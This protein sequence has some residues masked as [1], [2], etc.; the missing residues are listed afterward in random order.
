MSQEIS[1]TTTAGSDL[2]T[3]V[4]LRKRDLM[5]EL[6]EHKKNSSRFSSTAAMER[7]RGR[8]SELAH[9]IKEGVGDD[10]AHVGPGAKRK[11]EYWITK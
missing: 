3:R 7:I 2:E 8:L 4:A 9:I 1:A 5:S 10:W 6:V 11:L